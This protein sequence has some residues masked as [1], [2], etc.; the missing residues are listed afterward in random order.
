MIQQQLIQS[1]MVLVSLLAY[2]VTV[3]IHYH[4]HQNVSASFL[5]HANPHPSS[6]I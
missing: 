2:Y 4:Q 3:K 5:N 6:S 1:T